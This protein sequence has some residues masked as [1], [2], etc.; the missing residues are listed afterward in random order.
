[1][2]F[3]DPSNFAEYEKL[4]KASNPTNFLPFQRK[5]DS[6]FSDLQQWMDSGEEPAESGTE[7]ESEEEFF[8]SA[9][10]FPL[11]LP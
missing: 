9:S 7:S 2:R 4:F 6:F 5:V 10:D 11:C 3:K 1:M 8:V